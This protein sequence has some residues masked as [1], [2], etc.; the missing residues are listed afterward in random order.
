MT[1][2]TTNPAERKQA[3]VAKPVMLQNFEW[4]IHVYAHRRDWRTP[5]LCVA[6]ITATSVMRFAHTGR[7]SFLL[8]NEGGWWCRCYKGKSKAENSKRK[9]FLWFAP[10]VTHRCAGHAAPDPVQHVGGGVTQSPNTSAV[11]ALPGHS[12]R[13][14]GPIRPHLAQQDDC[15]TLY[16]KGWGHPDTYPRTRP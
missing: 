13:G 11:H 8:R 1:I 9:G 10:N 5:S 6:F 15:H 4:V 12:E 16:E 14:I 7:S 2:A 3:A